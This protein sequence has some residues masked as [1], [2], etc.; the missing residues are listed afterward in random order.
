A[1]ATRELV[2]WLDNDLLLPAGFIAAPVHELEQGGLGYL[3]A[4]TKNR[5]LRADESQRVARGECDPRGCVPINTLSSCR[6]PSGSGAAGL[7]RR[8][9]LVRHG[10]LIE[11]FRGWGGED[12]AWRHKVSLLGRFGGS[13]RA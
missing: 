4:F 13:R 10:G 8:E 12:N 2:L 9:F 5:Y 3:L 6:Q 7:V 11:G 1:A